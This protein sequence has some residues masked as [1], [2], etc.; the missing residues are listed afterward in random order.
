MAATSIVATAT[1]AGAQTFECDDRPATIVGTNG[2]DVIRGTEGPDVIVALGGNDK[3]FGL[4]GGDVICGG[5]GNDRIRGQKGNDLIIGGSGN[6]II[7]GN[8]GGDEIFGLTGKD[9]IWGGVGPDLIHGGPDD[10]VI[11]AGHGN[12]V[13]VGGEGND[14][15]EGSTGADG[16]VGDSGADTLIGGKGF[17][18]LHGGDGGDLLIGGPG[19]DILRGDLGPNRCRIDHNDVFTDCK[20]GNVKGESGEGFGRFRV[21]LPRDFELNAPSGPFYVLHVNS[22]PSGEVG[23]L[24]RIIIRD[25]NREVIFDAEFR[26]VTEHNV[27]IQGVPS[28]VEILGA[29]EWHLSFLKESAVAKNQRAHV[30]NSDDVFAFPVSPDGQGQATTVRVTN[31][32]TQPERILIMS[33]GDIGLNVELDTTIAAGAEELF[34]GPTRGS[35][36]Y[37]AVYAPKPVVWL[38]SLDRFFAGGSAEGGAPGAYGID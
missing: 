33:I 34:T 26:S 2:A 16:L 13:A 11:K 22:T 7:F 1:P 17:D 15:I 9:I 5:P 8:A 3:I 14:R 36:R 19:D 35:A 32:S 24:T 31:T 6:D 38:W 28:E 37:I 12:D 20:G 10:D 21:D 18:E 23:D 25:P 4:G 27:L 30:G 29:S